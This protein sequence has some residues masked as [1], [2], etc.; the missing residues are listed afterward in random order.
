[1]KRLN[2]AWLALVLVLLTW[3]S[4][5]HGGDEA[6]AARAY[7]DWLDGTILA[8]DRDMPTITAA[9][10]LAAER[11]IGGGQLTCDGEPGLRAELSHR[12]GGLGDFSAKPPAEGDVVL[13]AMGV[14]T[15]EQPDAATLLQDQLARCRALR[16]QGATVVGLASMAQLQQLNLHEQ[17]LQACHAL[18]DNHAPADDGLWTQPQTGKSLVP[19][20]VTANAVVAWTWCAELVAACTRQGRMPVVLQSVM[21]DGA[22]PRNLAVKGQRFHD[23][24][25]VPAMEKGVLGH[26]YLRE[27]QQVL[28]N[29]GT[30]SWPAL[31]Q[32]AQAMTQVLLDGDRVLVYAAGHYPPYHHAGQL[33]ADPALYAPMNL[34]RKGLTVQE[35][36]ARDYVL[37]IGYSWLPGDKL[38]GKPELFDEAAR[39]VCY[40]ITTYQDPGVAQQEDARKIVVDQQWP[41]GDALVEIPGYDVRFGPPSGVTSMAIFWAITAQVA[42]DVAE[43]QGAAAKP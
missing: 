31:A 39:G 7:M 43:Q 32:A 21:V 8:V 10:E 38:W 13:Y 20:F 23:P 4:A 1:M 5:L 16:E 33:A 27:L 30:Q 18:L 24:H 36:T 22:R 12:A 28:L 2:L 37:A 6:P 26:G 35:T 19:T 3:A 34:L 11:W 17:A 25:Q 29:V 14:R 41:Q 42:Q 9:A 15:R 40:I